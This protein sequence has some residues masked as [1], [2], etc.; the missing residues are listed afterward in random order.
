MPPEA[1]LLARR[2]HDFEQRRH[3]LW[4]ALGGVPAGSGAASAATRPPSTPSASGASPFLEPARH[5]LAEQDFRLT[6]ELRLHVREHAV[7]IEAYA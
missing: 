2:H 4:D 1:P 3:V 6:D 5:R 7:E